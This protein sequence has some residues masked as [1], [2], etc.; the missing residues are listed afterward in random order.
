MLRTRDAYLMARRVGRAL[1]LTGQ[2]APRLAS[3]SMPCGLSSRSRGLWESRGGLTQA[4]ADL[5]SNAA[6]K[7]PLFT[8]WCGMRAAG[9]S[10]VAHCRSFDCPGR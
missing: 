5:L 2:N 9:I 8:E 1:A 4:A 7:P 6:P 3:V 10:D